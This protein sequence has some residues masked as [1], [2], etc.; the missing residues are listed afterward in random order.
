MCTQDHTEQGT[1][2]GEIGRVRLRTPAPSP[3]SHPCHPTPQCAASQT[4]SQQGVWV[5]MGG[6]CLDGSK[7]MHCVVVNCMLSLNMYFVPFLHF[8]DPHELAL[9]KLC[10]LSEVRLSE[11]A[12]WLTLTCI[13]RRLKKRTL[14]PTSFSHGSGAS[15]MTTSEE[16]TAA[17]QELHASGAM[18]RTDF[19][20]C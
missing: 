4:A 1:A 11:T 10:T 13:R 16:A 2:L 20:A 17:I 12:A 6:K 19:I 18:T 7:V 3:K 14:H 5:A 15:I 8:S 9:T